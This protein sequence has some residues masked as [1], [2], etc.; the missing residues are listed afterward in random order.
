[1][2]KKHLEAITRENNRRDNWAACN[3]AA[4]SVKASIGKV[5]QDAVYFCYGI[6]KMVATFPSA[7][8]ENRGIYLNS[9]KYRDKQQ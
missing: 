4:G 5:S 9:G 3:F 2:T 8:E 1:M 6:G 7:L